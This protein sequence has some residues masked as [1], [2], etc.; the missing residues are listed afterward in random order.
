MAGIEG[1]FA[2]LFADPQIAALTVVVVGVLIKAI[3]A[4]CNHGGAFDA[5]LTI[6]SSIMGIL[7]GYAI[8]FASLTAASVNGVAPP[9]DIPHVIAGIMTVIGTDKV[10]K[11]VGRIVKKKPEGYKL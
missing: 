4:W 7:G 10:A 11:D 6:R 1:T 5:R 2:P 9:I 3:L 8:V